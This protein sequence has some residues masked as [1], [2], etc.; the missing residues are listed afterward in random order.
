MNNLKLIVFTLLLV[1]F[2]TLIHFQKGQIFAL[3]DQGL[4]NFTTQIEGQDFPKTL[5]DTTGIKFILKKTP[6]RI[7][8][9]TLA[10]DHML[11]G[12]IN[13]QRLVAVSSYVDTPSMSNIVGF[14]DKSIYRTQGEIESMLVLQPDLVFVASYSNPETVRYLLRSGIAIV[15]LSEFNSFADIFNNIR[16]IANVTDTKAAG[17]TMIVDL[18]KR[19]AFIKMQ[20]KDKKPPRVL[21][22]DLNGY[23]V[24]GN[25]LM[26]EAIQLSGGINVTNDVLADGENKISEELAIS[27]QPDVIVMNQWIFNQAE[28]QVSPRTILKNKKAWAD[29]PAVKNNH[30]YAVPGTWLRSVSQHRIKGVEAIA[31]LLHPAIESYPEKINVH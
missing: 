25:S 7:I 26:D 15:R 3:F 1:F 19:I 9:A 27:L 23:S 29:V 8:S 10:T 28:G 12:L 31:Q 4:G 22:Y 5:I 11:S 24:G 20:V 21:Y 2:I 14:F 18:Q 30:I 6:V 16:I 17:E 13:P